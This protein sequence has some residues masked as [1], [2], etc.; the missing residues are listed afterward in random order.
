MAETLLPSLTAN[1]SQPLY[2]LNIAGGPAVDSLNTLIVLN[3]CHPGILTKREVLIDVLD[4]DSVGPA[5][6]QK[7]L[8]ALSEEGGPLRGIQV[9]FRHVPYDW[10]SAADLK[11]VLSQ[12]QAKG[13]LVICS[14]E[15]GLFEYGSDD[16][17]KS[18]L[19]VLRDF[20]E[21]LAVVGSVTR[22]DEPTQRL[23]Q[24]GAAATRPRGLAVF[25]TL[26]Q[27]VGWTVSRAIERPFSD[28]VVLA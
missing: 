24:T 9:A 20:P 28:Q 15:G 3:K 21:V 18:D 2:F 1:P 22:A 23:R 5:F 25:H 13:A 14:S 8:A 19:K 7:A 17:I 6:G 11:P 27:Q 26:V 16:E 10:T 12:A 4:R